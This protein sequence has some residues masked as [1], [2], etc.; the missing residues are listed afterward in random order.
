MRMRR[1]LTAFVLASACLALVH[2]AMADATADAKKA[3]QAAYNAGNAA[4]GKKDMNKMFANDSPDFVAVRNG[5]TITLAQAKAAVK[6]FFPA[7]K[8]IKDVSVV[9]K[10]KLKGNEATVTVKEHGDMVMANPQTKKTMKISVDSVSEDVWTKSGGAWLRK[11]SKSISEH[12]TSDGKPVPT[13]K[14]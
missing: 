12:V 6:Q 9:Q 2:G 11:R 8:S 14:H 4:T 1:N 13:G 5:Q 10:I 3:I 7:V